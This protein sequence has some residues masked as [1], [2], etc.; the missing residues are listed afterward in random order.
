MPKQLIAYAKGPY[1][2]GGAVAAELPSV[3]TEPMQKIFVDI[4]TL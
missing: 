2:A 4:E 1:L 3:P